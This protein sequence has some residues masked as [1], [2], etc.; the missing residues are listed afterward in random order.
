MRRKVNLFVVA[1]A[2]GAAVLTV[3]PFLQRRF[4]KAPPPTHEY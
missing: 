3:L 4:L 2:V 1:F